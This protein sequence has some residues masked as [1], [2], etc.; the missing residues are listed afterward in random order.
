MSAGSSRAPI[1]D[2]KIK[3]LMNA[4][5][6][7]IP[8]IQESRPIK[9][10][11]RRLPVE[12][13]CEFCDAKFIIHQCVLDKGCGKFCSKSCADKAKTRPVPERFFSNVL[14]TTSCWLWTGWV[15]KGNKYGGFNMGR[16]TVSAHR[17]SWIIHN[18][19]IPNGLC[20]LR[21]CP[22][23]DNPLCVNPDHLWLG[24]NADNSNDMC[25]KKRQAVGDNNG[26]R[27]YPEKLKRGV[28]NSK[29]KL[30]EVKVRDIRL[31]F[32]SGESYNSIGRHYGIDGSTVKR[33]VTGKTWRHVQ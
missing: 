6:N 1:A 5:E 10:P 20:V 31:R 30:D 27:L 17:A 8:V 2:S 4:A 11:H 24:T 9:N 19:S 12:K 22:D 29:A 15:F 7:T 13:L 33:A 26:S 18:G 3:Q 28:D 14:K 32:A 25:A 16:K 23:G 21:N